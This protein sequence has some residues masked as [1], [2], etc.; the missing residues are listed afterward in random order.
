VLRW[1]REERSPVPTAG[2]IVVRE[3]TAKGGRRF[4]VSVARCEGMELS[5]LNDEAAAVEVAARLGSALGLPVERASAS[6]R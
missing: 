3:A 1:C 2:A 5:V 4:T 6:R